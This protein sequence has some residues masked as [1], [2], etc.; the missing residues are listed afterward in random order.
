M[1][2]RRLLAGLAAA[3][4]AAFS[5]PMNVFAAG[6]SIKAEFGNA[7][8]N[9][10]DEVEISF[11]VTEN[12]GFCT[13]DLG[14]TW[15]SDKVELIKVSPDYDTEAGEDILKDKGFPVFE[16]ES[17]MKDGKPANRG[18]LVLAFGKP[19]AQDPYTN[20]ADD[21]LTFTFRIKDTVTAGEEI[22]IESYKG[23]ATLPKDD[24]TKVN[25]DVTDGKITIAC[26]HKESDMQLF[27][28]K[29]PT[30]E[31]EGNIEYYECS[32]CGKYFKDK[33]AHVEITDKASVKKAKLGHKYGDPVYTWVGNTECTG[34]V[35]CERDAK[36]VITEKAKISYKVTADATCDK[37]GI[38]TYTATFTDEH[39]TTQT[40][41]DHTDPK[42][43]GHDWTGTPS[44]KWSADHKSCTATLK[45]K[46]CSETIT[47]K[48]TVTEKTTPA[49]GC[50]DGETVY[51]ATFTDSRFKTQTYTEVIEAKDGHIWGDV[52][53]EWDN[54]RNS[55][56]G[57][58]KCTICGTTDEAVAV[59]VE[60]TVLEESTCT[61]PGRTEYTAIFDKA[62]Y[63]NQTVIDET[64]PAAKGHKYGAVKYTWNEDHTACVAERVCSVCKDVDSAEAATITKEVTEATCTAE[65][66]IVYTATFT[67]AG[68]ADTTDEVVLPMV[69]H[70]PGRP[71]NENIESG[72][73]CEEERNA[74]EVVYCTVCKKELSRKAVVLEPGKHAEGEPVRENVVEATC[75][76]DGS[77][78]EVVYCTQCGFEVSREE[79]IVITAK[80][81][82]YQ[83]V[84]ENVV[85]ATCT[86]AGSYDEVVKCSVCGDVE[87][88]TKVDVDAL[89]HEP[90]E[91]VKENEVAATTEAE[92][93]YDEVV[94]CTRCRTSFYTSH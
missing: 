1:K 50:K 73:S 43:K 7:T 47:A 18:K 67:K 66:K 87:S 5:L 40:M 52:K 61:E 69:D 15:D 29:D 93:S 26:P 23:L 77:Y 20:T 34:T 81:H 13:F 30:C 55:C 58:R 33:T 25:I 39:F 74:E 79:G 56:K 72:K 78:D 80:G 22:K 76:E 19:T 63:E 45:C 85:E 68:F 11:S 28:A 65:G 94:Y 36:H 89:G 37:P 27:R 71:V 59:A 82:D 44:Y 17:I 16:M 3:V 62:G 64:V 88:T 14:F 46:N 8:G 42:A 24:L 9:A 21:L 2:K 48:A 92:G 70:T 4:M 10:G 57:T 90:G 32:S 12:T 75:T 53:Y 84:K 31:A 91:A 38:T 49:V 83:T 35:V 60:T 54:S 6:E 86:E 41:N 51:T